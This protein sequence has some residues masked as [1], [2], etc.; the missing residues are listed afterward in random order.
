MDSISA[1]Q[2]YILGGFYQ[3]INGVDSEKTNVTVKFIDKDTGA[4]LNTA[5][6]ADALNN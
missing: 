1:I 5:N 3:V 2:F 6:S 4:V